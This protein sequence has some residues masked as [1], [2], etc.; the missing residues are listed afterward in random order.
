MESIITFFTEN[1]YALV[2]ALVSI[3]SSVATLI[4]M[5]VDESK[6]NKYIK[7]VLGVLNW[8]AGNVFKNKNATS[9]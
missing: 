3:V 5:F 1:G 6:V 2:I 4:T 9:K 7:P 8:L